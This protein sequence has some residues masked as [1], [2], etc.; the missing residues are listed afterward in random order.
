MEIFNE[1]VMGNYLNHAG[2][3]NYYTSNFYSRVFY[4][5]TQPCSDTISTTNKMSRAQRILETR[6]D[7]LKKLIYTPGQEASIPLIGHKTAIFSERMIDHYDFSIGS[8]VH[9]SGGESYVFTATIKPF[10][11]MD[12]PNGSVVKFLE[13][14]MD[15]KSY[16]VL[17]RKY[18]L[19][20][21]AGVYNFDVLMLVNLGQHQGK[22]VPIDIRYDGY[23]KVVGKKK[24]NCAFHF[25]ITEFKTD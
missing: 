15:K 8:G 10:F 19:Q 1:Q 22:Y 18:K 23:W 24:E 12:Y 21:N 17:S 3:Y 9:E 11:N 5:P 14:T 20:Y 16:Q 25:K 6:T 7:E 2:D 13:I 4:K